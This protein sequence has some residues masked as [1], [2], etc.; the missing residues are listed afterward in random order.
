[1]PYWMIRP[2]DVG[3]EMLEH[4][5]SQEFSACLNQKFVIH[6]ESAE[7]LEVD[8]IQVE[9]LGDAAESKRRRPFSVIFRGAPE[10]VLPQQIY[11]IE[12]PKMG[13]LELF[14]VPIGPDDVGMRFEAVFA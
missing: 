3:S 11:P 2:P 7:K 8:L 13:T 5:T 14:I 12:H 1:M 4:L 6:L 9:D 10:Y